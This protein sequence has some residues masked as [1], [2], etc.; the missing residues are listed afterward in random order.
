MVDYAIRHLV[1]KVAELFITSS[2]LRCCITL[3]LINNNTKCTV[4]LWTSYIYLTE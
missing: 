2:M 1:T 3:F 4:I